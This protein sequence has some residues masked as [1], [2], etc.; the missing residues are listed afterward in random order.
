[1][2]A[3]LW[4]SRILLSSIAV[5]GV[6]L[7][8]FAQNKAYDFDER[9]IQ[10]AVATAIVCAGLKLISFLS[11]SG[12]PRWVW[13]LMTLLVIV[14]CSLA[15]VLICHETL[16][17][18]FIQ[19]E[20]ASEFAVINMKLIPVATLFA[21]IAVISCGSYLEFK[22]TV[23]AVALT[24][25]C[26]ALIESAFWD[27]PNSWTWSWNKDAGFDSFYYLGLA[28]VCSARDQAGPR[29]YWAYVGTIAAIS[30]WITA[31]TWM[32][33]NEYSDYRETVVSIAIIVAAVVAHLNLCSFTN[34][35]AR[36]IW[37]RRTA[38]SC[39]I[40]TAVLVLLTKLNWSLFLRL[41]S[42]FD[43]LIAYNITFAGASLAATASIAICLFTI[44]NNKKVSR[45]LAEAHIET[46][47]T[48][49][50]CRRRQIAHAGRFN[51]KHCKLQIS[52]EFEEPRC[53][54]CEYLLVGSTG[55][56]C[57]ECGHMIAAIS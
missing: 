38:I 17:L 30:A 27:W 16:D 9:L 51:C 24:I 53:T 32:W 15:N 31:H 3:G 48:C 4:I 7:A 45:P 1:M 14:E 2:T 19:F 43:E 23:C 5:T 46:E 25:F 22:G 50:R 47:L 28:I 33:T 34:L 52:V 57:P 39:S 44:E 56:A 36:Q 21:V 41:T 29:K 35:S 55:E 6:A 13:T 10:M 20:D 12:C 26:F 18:A 54:K 40:I 11:T 49:P 37:V 42:P 8:G